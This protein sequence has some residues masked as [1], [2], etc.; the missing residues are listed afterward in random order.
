M[1][2]STLGF[3]VAGIRRVYLDFNKTL[4]VKKKI[5]MKVQYQIN[6]YNLKI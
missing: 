5:S 3:G 1:F 6:T 2:N 4:P